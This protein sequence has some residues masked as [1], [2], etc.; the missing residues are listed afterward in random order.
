M[1]G[2]AIALILMVNFILQSTVLQFIAILGV[3]PDTALAIVVALGIFT[4]NEQG[5]LIGATAGLLQDIV[6]GKPVGITALSYMLIGYIVGE[7]SGKVFKE[8]MVVPLIFTAVATLIKY[9]TVVFFN[10]VLGVPTSIP[11]YIGFYLPIE[12]IYNCVVSVLLYKVLYRASKR[13]TIKERLRIK[14]K[15]R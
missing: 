14:R 13:K 9:I 11:N 1:S 4:G 15:G 3:M 5:A 12:V 2:W 6:F 10:Y 8:H 7:N